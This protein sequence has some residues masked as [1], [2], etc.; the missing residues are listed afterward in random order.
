MMSLASLRL[1]RQRRDHLRTA[2][3]RR[4]RTNV[5]YRVWRIERALRAVNAAWIAPANDQ[6][7]IQTEEVAA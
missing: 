1:R 5:L 7:P 2:V 4:D 6:S 3:L